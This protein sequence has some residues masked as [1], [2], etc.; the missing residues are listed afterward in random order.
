MMKTAAVIALLM[1]SG[2]SFI[3]VSGPPRA[4]NGHPI[5]CT[6]DSVLPTLDLAGSVLGWGVG[7]LVAA[8]A[9]GLGNDPRGEV[10]VSSPFPIVGTAFAASAIYGSGAESRCRSAKAKAADA[11]AREQAAARPPGND[12]SNATEFWCA[13]SGDGSCWTDEPHCQEAGGGSLRIDEAWCARDRAADGAAQFFCGST[14]EACL[15][16][17]DLPKNRSGSELGDCVFHTT[18]L[19]R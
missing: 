12:P 16:V 9:Y 7:L 1:F 8:A 14:R 11:I 19:A 13:S 4:S 18:A 10:L 15:I 2:C 6:D 17:R 5:E 3:S